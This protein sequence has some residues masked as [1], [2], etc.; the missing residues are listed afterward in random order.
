MPL[1]NCIKYNIMVI[2]L[3]TR[4]YTIHCGKLYFMFNMET[5]G[6]TTR[7]KKG[8]TKQLKPLDMSRAL[9]NV[10]GTHAWGMG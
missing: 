4:G 9:G 7:N 1:D 3:G 8:R 6:Y 10:Q 5:R 2:G